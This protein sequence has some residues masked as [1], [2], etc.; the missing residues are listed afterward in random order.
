MSELGRARTMM[1]ST[2]TN[3]WKR[4]WKKE[5]NPS[6]DE[7][8]ADF[9]MLWQD[10]E[11]AVHKTKPLVNWS[12][13]VLKSGTTFLCNNV[14]VTQKNDFFRLF[15][16]GCT[17][18]WIIKCTSVSQ[19]STAQYMNLQ[20][21]WSTAFTAFFVSH[22]NVVLSPD[23]KSSDPEIEMANQNCAFTHFIVYNWAF[24]TVMVSQCGAV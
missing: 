9:E 2:A 24:P 22:E 7:S 1:W 14:R 20:L 3:L 6:I 13:V 8:V 17:S 5:K 4:Y 21:V 12:E 10:L 15:K 18:S 11:R 16:D 23:L 19:D